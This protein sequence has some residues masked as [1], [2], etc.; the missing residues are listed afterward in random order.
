MGYCNGG[1]AGNLDKDWTDANFFCVPQLLR[2]RGVATRV[3]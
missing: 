2:N 1:M 3:E